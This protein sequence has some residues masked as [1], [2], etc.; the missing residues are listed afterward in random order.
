MGKIQ[1]YSNPPKVIPVA[2][3]AAKSSRDYK[4]YPKIKY[5]VS[6]GSYTSGDIVDI[7]DLGKVA[8]IDFTGKKETVA[9]VTQRDDG[10]FAPVTYTFA[11]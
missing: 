2:T 1:P 5:Y 10:T 9:Q 11:K 7:A 4:V 3:W 6:T 8:T